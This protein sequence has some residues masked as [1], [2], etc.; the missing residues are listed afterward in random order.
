MIRPNSFF[1]SSVEK[2]CQAFVFEGLYHEQNCN[3]RG[4]GGQ[5]LFF[6]IILIKQKFF[7]IFRLTGEILNFYLI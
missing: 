7:R 6:E 4:Y 1:G 2:I 5:F 3:P